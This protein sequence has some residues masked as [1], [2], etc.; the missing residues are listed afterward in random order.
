[1][2]R[3][4]IVL[5]CALLCLSCDKIP[6]KASS[7][8]A[9]ES[10]PAADVPSF[11]G[12]DAFAFLLKQ[13]SFGPRNPESSGH[14]L[15]LD[16]LKQ[17]LQNLASRTE[18][19][20]FTAPG[21]NGQKLHLTNIFSS[22]NPADSSRILLLA[23]WD[24]RPRSDQDSNPKKQDEP[25]IGAN[26]G[27]SGVAVLLEI[28]HLLKQSPVRVGV[29]I[30]LVDGEDYGKESDL[31][32]YLLGSK[33]FANHLK[34]DYH[35]QFGILLDMVGDK[36]LEIMKEP[37]S[38]KY[39]PEVVDLVWSAANN[40]GVYQFT[41]NIQRAVIDDHIP[42]NE[43]GIK[44]IDLIDFQYPDASNRFWHTSEDTPDKCSAESLEAVGR[45][46][47]AVIYHHAV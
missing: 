19:Q 27:A 13:T 9:D 46:L 30:L 10:A 22:F 31:D 20:S 39:A 18:L 26:D 15:C 32:N 21:Y 4:L 8:P 17:E 25:I 23:H 12:Q 44:T 42:L 34:P 5:C 14:E 11:S 37:Q 38:M 45:V 16:F 35:P 36:D 33:Y 3:T 29:D 24:T 40:L 6:K 28:A 43:A 47:T 2:K 41:N 7:P 1:M